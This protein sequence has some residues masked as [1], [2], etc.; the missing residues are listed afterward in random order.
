MQTNLN[1]IL[2]DG[3]EP[4]KTSTEALLSPSALGASA[5]GAVMRGSL[6]PQEALSLQ[7]TKEMLEE[8][9]KAVKAGDLSMLEETLLNQTFALNV[10]FTNLVARAS[11]QEDISLISA[12]MNLAFKAQNQSRM[13]IDSLVNLKN[14][15][16][17]AF[18]KQQ[19]NIAHGH[20]QVNNS[21]ES[22]P[23]LHNKLLGGED[24]V[25]LQMDTRAQ[26]IAKKSSAKK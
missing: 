11:R 21:L 9:F 24:N 1:V 23:D 7:Y 25:R 5:F 19:T 10:A 4:L 16:Q 20:Q 6:I 14:P 15:S 8:S 2:K 18:I 3:E 12:M 17:T 22:N 26:R 13:T